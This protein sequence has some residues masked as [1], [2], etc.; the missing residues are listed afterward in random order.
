MGIFDSYL[1]G[2]QPLDDEDKDKDL[3]AAP[4]A[5]APAMTP[6]ADPAD[7][8]PNFFQPFLNKLAKPETLP[9]A[10]PR[11]FGSVGRGINRMEQ[12]GALGLQQLG[13]ISPETAGQSIANDEFDISRLPPSQA[14]T[15]GQKEIQDA[16]GWLPKTGAI[17][18]NP[19]A[20]LSSVGESIPA[21]MPSLALGAAGL[22]SP[23]PGGAA[24]GYGIGSGLTEMA[25]TMFDT[26]RAAGVDTSDPKAVAAALQNPELMSSARTHGAVR[27]AVVGGFD[28]L[29]GGLAGR[30]IMPAAQ[31][32]GR[33]ILGAIGELGA[34]GLAGAGGE[35]GA[36]LADQGK[37]TNKED[38]LN[39]FF[40]ELVPGA[41]EVAMGSHAHGAAHAEPTIPAAPT[42][43]DGFNPSDEQ[44]Q[45]ATDVLGRMNEL[46]PGI[47]ANTMFH[48]DIAAE[49]Q[50]AVDS[51]GKLG[52]QQAAG[53]YDPESGLINISLA[54]N[55]D[56]NDTAFHELFHHFQRRANADGTETGAF[57][58]NEQEALD[59][60]FTNDMKFSDF[61]AFVKNA[62]GEDDFNKMAE[63]RADQ[64]YS[65]REAQAVAFAAYY[66][67]R[68]SGKPVVGI[69]PRIKQ[70]FE[71][72]YQKISSLGEFLKGRGIDSAE[73]V[74]RNAADGKISDRVQV[75]P[76]AAPTA[77]PEAPT[78]TPQEAPRAAQTNAN[79]EPTDE[80]QDVP[81][82]AVLPPGLEI[83]MDLESGRQQARRVPGSK[84]Q[85]QAQPNPTF[86][87]D[88]GF[89]D[90]DY[91][92]Q[93]DKPEVDEDGVVTPR[94]FAMPYKPNGAQFTDNEERTGSNGMPLHSTPILRNGARPHGRINEEM[95]ADIKKAW[96][97]QSNAP[98]GPVNLN[99]GRAMKWEGDKTIDK[100][101]GEAPG[102]FKAG[103]GMEHIMGNHGAEISRV[104]RKPYS[105]LTPK[106]I[107]DFVA[108]VGQNFQQIRKSPG[109]AIRLVY[110]AGEG[111]QLRYRQLGIQPNHKTGKEWLVNTVFATNKI[112]GDR[113][114]GKD[115]RQQEHP[116]NAAEPGGL[117]ASP[118]VSDERTGGTPAESR[119]DTAP[120]Q[121]VP[122]GTQSQAPKT[123]P[124]LTLKKPRVDMDIG[125]SSLFNEH[126]AAPETRS[127]FM[128]ASETERGSPAHRRG[129]DILTQRLR[130]EMNARKKRAADHDFSQTIDPADI[131]DVDDFMTWIG[132]EMYSDVGISITRRMGP[133]GRFNYANDMVT[134][135]GRAIDHGEVTRTMIHE[136]FHAAQRVL[137]A[138]D[139][140]A[141]TKSYQQAIRKYLS[142]HPE[143]VPFT[144][145]EAGMTHMD[146]RS[147]TGAKAVAYRA[148][149]QT[150]PEG[151]RYSG[152]NNDVRLLNTDEN[153]RYTNGQEFF[154][155]TMLDKY[156]D[157]LD[158]Y[159]E[160]PTTLFGKIVA[161]TAKTYDRIVNAVASRFGYR[162]MERI[163]SNFENKS[164]DV[165][166]RNI[167]SQI[168][169]MAEMERA[170]VS[171]SSPYNGVGDPENP[172]TQWVHVSQPTE[173]GP[174]TYVDAYGGETHESAYAKAKDNLPGANIQPL[175]PYEA[176]QIDAAA[177][178]QMYSVP[179]RAMGSAAQE[180]AIDRIQPKDDERPLWRKVY[181]GILTASNIDKIAVEQSMVDGFASIAAHERAGNKGQLRDARDS[182]VKQAYATKNLGSV[183][184]AVMKHGG[185]MLDR[186]GG[187]FKPMDVTWTNPRTGQVEKIEGFENIFTDLAKKGQMRLWSGW[188][189]A[190]RS[191]RLIQEGR[192]SR[193]SQ[194]EIDELLKLGQQYPDFQD[195]MGKWTAFN[196]SILDMAQDAGVIDPES[197]KI[198]EQNDYVPFYRLTEDKDVVG[199]KGQRGIASQRS[200][201]KTLKGADASINDLIENMVLNMTTLVDASFKNFAMQKIAP[202]MESVGAMEKIT[203]EKGMRG[204]SIPVPMAVRALKKLGVN[205]SNLT[206]AQKDA[207]AKVFTFLPNK[208]P[209]VVH[210]LENGKP[211][212]Y[213][214]NDPLLMRAVGSL[215]YQSVEGFTKLMRGAKRT[216][217]NF[218]TLDPGFMIANAIRDTMA[219]SIMNKGF[220]PDMQTFAGAAK[221]FNEDKS[222]VEL[223]ASGAGGAGFYHTSP[224]EVS[225]SLKKM[226]KLSNQSKIA[227]IGRMLHQSLEMFH[228]LGMATENMNRIK[229]YEKLIKEGKSQAEAAYQA[230]DMMNFSMRGDAAAIR[231]MAEVVP[232]MNARVQGLYKLYRAAKEDPKGV[233]LRGALLT[234]GTMALYGMNRDDDRYKDLAEWDK[235]S[236]YHFWIG[237][238]HFRI[239]K[240]FE[241]GAIFSTIPERMALLLEGTDQGKQTWDAAKRM[242]GDTFAMNP[243][244]QLFLPLAEDWANKETFYNRP[245][246]GQGLQRLPN[247]L[248]YTSD[249]SAVAKAVTGAMPSWVKGTPVI[250]DALTSPVRMEHLVNGYFGTIGS[251]M[252]GA[253][254]A[255]VRQFDDKP[256]PS[257][258]TDQIPVI[259]RFFRES[260]ELSTKWA[261]E[262]YDMKDQTDKLYSAISTLR[263]QGDVD[264]AMKIATENRGQLSA[265]TRLNAIDKQLTQVR[266]QM[267]KVQ[268]SPTM[269][270]VE[271]RRR[272]DELIDRRNQISR[273]AEG[274]VRNF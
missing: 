269:A 10:Q 87:E 27:G 115:A 245:I 180:S 191:Q 94:E 178:P 236:N 154:A 270:P 7:Q 255:V 40:G 37:I 168:H 213:R 69:K 226:A 184:A 86:E 38:V 249:T 267:Q 56:V 131:K 266:Q 45:K 77:T 122:Q 193:L 124:T 4:E 23:V 165:S 78:A 113:V 24:A 151:V 203:P 57:N 64:T 6:A 224:E 273:R 197:R 177:Q 8:Q 263:K 104:L 264:G 172:A 271:K 250:G 98:V 176:R 150:A 194:P 153:Y 138:S 103:F 216:L 246:V 72:L 67:A 190:N 140:Q 200:G 43:A 195:A 227:G 272:L 247:E 208:E 137:P 183:M 92:P 119:P 142:A 79:F 81:K 152:E 100:A 146:K 75:N 141:V 256:N 254:D 259:K 171:Q 112:N 127:P 12:A 232:F 97:E 211:V 84:P 18:S 76:A 65:S 170:P 166:N 68:K 242:I 169:Q 147:L 13:V 199:P 107:S 187:I 162:H 220:L 218:I 244:P 222:F 54:D 262:F 234:M 233:L 102:K 156:Q 223:M 117:A 36:Q 28:A 243:V 206:D 33:P 5:A 219:A 120:A 105:K 235:D 238:S 85:A 108:Q 237:D 186:A 126:R 91:G 63:T 74:F 209:D 29:S 221:A 231:F 93:Y 49:G 253:S 16:Q 44:R 240:P 1:V 128:L 212:Y 50:A 123:R 118:Y 188:A 230:R 53:A 21:S 189:I 135:F 48:P 35:A 225:G 136:M 181:D 51:G 241:L 274:V 155:E 228:R 41:A 39:E 207:W 179:P 89:D 109:G 196:K 26:M 22:A 60:T 215:G 163:F 116:V 15:E 96:G 133:L 32:A 70:A 55:I 201:I 252:L 205:V 101:T 17:L 214:V 134:L 258:R 61:P 73:S 46:V 3:L 82:D 125:E 268:Q 198:W 139:M 157:M 25:S 143:L 83:K 265:R 71:S 167:L 110:D 248:Q 204:M 145:T 114:W 62:M 251:Y 202:Q 185:L 129:A 58:A 99:Y 121:S 239:P 106:D 14:V 47:S 210:V 90:T 229:L 173:V 88:E 34:Q 9:P 130:G 59:N 257:L 52:K 19:S 161:F 158:G 159:D 95:V 174:M 175:T 132:R 42:F 31:A 148:E 164:Y 182:G 80:W 30:V 149:H 66:N 11:A 160:A 192:E 261:T 144:T 20:L 111:A 2:L 260:P 217:T